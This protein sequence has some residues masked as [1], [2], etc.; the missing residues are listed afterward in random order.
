[1][2]GAALCGSDFSVRLFA[3]ADLTECAR[4]FR[5]AWHAGHPYAPRQ[6]GLAEFRAETVGE[7]VLVAMSPAEQVLGFTGLQL[8]GSFV[9]HLYVDPRFH[10]CGVGRA[11]LAAAVRIAGGRA[12]LKCQ[13]GN[14]DALAFYRRLGWTD[15][16][17]GDS[18]IGPWVLMRSPEAARL[19]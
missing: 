5:H 9:H 14:P 6:L 1:M 7:V 10:R 4:I 18:A 13:Q 12:T 19:G 2:G 3:E 15:G 16:E 17:T 11:L 8:S